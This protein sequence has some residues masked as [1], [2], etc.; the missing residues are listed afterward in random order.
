MSSKTMIEAKNLS[1]HFERKI[2]L[3][4]LSF[5]INQGELVALIG[6]SGAGKTT[7]LNTIA[8]LISTE[9]GEL[10]IDSKPLSAYK[11]RKVIC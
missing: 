6:P 2:A 7:L 10:F 5:T 9:K 1:K 11:K 8:G 4:S 3:S